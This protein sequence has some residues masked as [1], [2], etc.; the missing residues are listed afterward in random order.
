[1]CIQVDISSIQSKWVGEEKNT[2]AIFQEY[3]KVCEILNQTNIAI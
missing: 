1:M 2:K 3:Y